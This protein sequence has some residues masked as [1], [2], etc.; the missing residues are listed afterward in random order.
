MVREEV[1]KVIISTNTSSLFYLF[2][3]WQPFLWASRETWS[4][5]NCSRCSLWILEK[6]FFRL[7]K[8][9][10]STFAKALIKLF[11]DCFSPSLHFPHQT[12]ALQ[13]VC[14]PAEPQKTLCTCF[15][16][17]RIMTSKLILMCTITGV[18]LPMIF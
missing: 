3:V 9:N 8:M 13:L 5:G 15:Y 18:C 4:F 6:L 12:T 11:E 14:A 1:I 10:Q 16:R 2:W 17:L 7:W